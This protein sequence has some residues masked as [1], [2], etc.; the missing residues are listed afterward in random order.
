[1]KPHGDSF[2]EDKNSETQQLLTYN[3]GMAILFLP[4]CGMAILFLPIKNI[5]RSHEAGNPLIKIL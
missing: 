1:M 5:L 2:K 4:N 3:C